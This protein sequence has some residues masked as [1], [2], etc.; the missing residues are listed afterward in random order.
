V[1]LLLLLAQT[2]LQTAPNVILLVP[3]VPLATVAMSSIPL[4]TPMLAL[5]AVL[6][7]AVSALLP[8]VLTNALPAKLVTD[9]LLVPLKLILIPAK[10]ALL[11]TAPLALL[12]LELALDASVDTSSLITPALLALTT[13]LTALLPPLAKPA[14]PVTPRPLKVPAFLDSRLVLASPSVPS[15]PSLSSPSSS[16]SESNLIAN[17]H[18]Q[19]SHFTQTFAWTRR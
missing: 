10:L 15:L 16:K 8:P 2:K 7:T 19:L 18:P 12:L 5:L 11:P 9:L 1:P 13:V 4:L 6:P 17:L 14:Q 3:F